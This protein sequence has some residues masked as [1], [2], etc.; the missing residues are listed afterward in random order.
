MT[1]T[2]PRLTET[3]DLGSSPGIRDPFEVVPRVL[4]LV[5]LTGAIFFRSD[6]RAPGPTRPLRPETSSGRCPRARAAW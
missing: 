6:F 2:P 4:D 5:R 1:E 3:P